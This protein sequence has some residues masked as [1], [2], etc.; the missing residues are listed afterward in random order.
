MDITEASDESETSLIATVSKILKTTAD[1]NL[2]PEDII[3]IHRIPSKQG[4]TRPIILKLRNNNAKS[5]IMKKRTQ[6]KTKGHRLVDDVTKRNQGLISRLLLHPDIKN[7]WFF[8]GSV[9]GLSTS[10]ER[11]KFDIFD[12][13]SNLI[14]DYRN[15]GRQFQRGARV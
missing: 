10:E 14:S 13:I 6:M 11:I 2:K 1:V 7:A 5:A 4:K 3:A 8:N 12:N 15:R 9:F